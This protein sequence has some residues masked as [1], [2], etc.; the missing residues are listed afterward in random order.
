MEEGRLEEVRLVQDFLLQF[1]PSRVALVVLV[2]QA[3]VP[4]LPQSCGA[5]DKVEQLLASGLRWIYY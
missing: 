2:L 1:E 5:A 3:E 4:G